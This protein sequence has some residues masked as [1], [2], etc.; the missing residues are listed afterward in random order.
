MAKQLTTDEKFEAKITKIKALWKKL[1]EDDKK[2]L[3]YIIDDE[4]IEYIAY[5]IEEQKK[6]AVLTRFKELEDVWEP[7]EVEKKEILNMVRNAVP[8]KPLDE[9]VDEN[10]LKDVSWLVENGFLALV[11]IPMTKPFLA[12]TK[13][14]L[15]EVI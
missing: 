13:K 9:I 4:V 5:E 11:N 14:G 1:G 15:G 3:L 7:N 6:D 10:T 2:K 8:F 12:L